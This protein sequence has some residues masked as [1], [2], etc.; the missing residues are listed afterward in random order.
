MEQGYPSH[1]DTSKFS[2]RQSVLDR[3]RENR[4][5]DIDLC[6]TLELEA[7]RVNT[8]KGLIIFG[9]FCFFVSLGFI[10]TKYPTIWGPL[11]LALAALS[12]WASHRY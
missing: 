9:M 10:N 5:K 11:L 2:L 3:E 6:V 1:F 12:W 8:Q 7:R 4:Q